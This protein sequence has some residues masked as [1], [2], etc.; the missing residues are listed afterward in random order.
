MWDFM[1]VFGGLLTALMLSIAGLGGA[2]VSVTYPANTAYAQTGPVITQIDVRGNRR[3]ESQ[4]VIGYLSIGKGERYDA[5]KVDLSFKALFATGLFEDVKIT[6]ERTT[7]IVTVV[8]NPIINRVAFEGNKKL[9]DAVL[10]AEVELRAR[11]VLTRTKVQNDLQR[12]LTLYRRSGRFAARVEPKIINLPQNRVDLVFE[13][14]EGDKTGVSRITFIGNKAFTDSD[15]RK[16]VTTGETGFLSFLRSNDI[17]DPDRL[18]ADQELLRR[19]YLRNGYA[20]FRIIS[21]VADL[22]QER[23]AFFIIITVEEGPLYA[24]G[25]IHIESNVRAIDP[26][27]LRGVVHTYEGDVYNLELIDRTLEDLTVEVSKLG[28]AFAQVSPR[29]ERDPVTHSVAL[30]FVINEGPRVYI[31]RIDIR[32]NTR[33]EDRV[34]RREF[35]LVEGDAYNRVLID[36]AERR[37]NGLGFFKTVKI[38][39]EPGS[40][41]DRVVVAVDVEE[42]PT[43]QLSVGVGYSTADGILGDVSISER[44]LLGRG[45]FVR[46]AVSVSGK[47]R[48]IDFSFTEP[49]F[50]ERRVAAGIDLFS[51][52]IDLTSES[53]Y[54]S[55]Q[56]G[57]GVR[58]GFPL[59]PDLSLTTRYQLSQE[60]I[61]DIPVTAS[62]AV[63]A[64]AGKSIAS[65]VG[66]SLRFDTVDNKQNPTD[67]LYMILSQDLAGVGGD[68]QYLRTTAEARLYQKI[69]EDFV[70]VFRVEGG[71]IFGI[72][73]DVRIADAFFKGGE[74][75]RGF[76]RAGLGPRD[77]TPG[78]NGDALGGTTYVAASAEVQFPIF[79]IPEE[80]GF[81][82]ALFADAGT[83]F[84]TD[85]KGNIYPDVDPVTPGSQP[86]TIT[87]L[88]SS[89]IRSSVGFS[90]LWNSPFGPL[91]A[92]FAHVLTSQSF[93]DE[94]SF[95]FGGGARF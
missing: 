40:A 28:Y 26:E 77:A 94:Q 42:Q 93:D 4:T 55:Q 89:S 91:R 30:T 15:L 63:L 53:S 9:T 24:F 10:G 21:A 27:L 34:V 18:A 79:G 67:G 65:L 45:Q 71:H 83:V 11:S 17:Y 7:L 73:D 33:T 23:N 44:N 37:L 52:E 90:V 78:Y 50:M 92:D 5:Y 82:G 80:L 84:G 61:T 12:I 64:E 38:T 60:E 59:T 6:L 86:G 76:A 46:L 36:R 72:G 3:V 81:K 39:R 35:D 68:V 22:D 95:R 14:T 49:Y 74:T 58:F 69:Y 41:P 70:G 48:D 16:V 2:V 31:E 32:G 19:H 54:K 25:A 62:P 66:Y 51:R 43:G 8:E 88:D 85:T 75:I 20:D 57:G 29:G 56:R 47:R 87:V 13:I 1:R